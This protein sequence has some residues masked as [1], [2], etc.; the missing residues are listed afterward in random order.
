MRKIIIVDADLEGGQSFGYYCETI[1]EQISRELGALTGRE[2]VE[3]AVAKEYDVEKLGEGDVLV[4][5]TYQKLPEGYEQ[6]RKNP[7]LKVVVLTA[8]PQVVVAQKEWMN[9]PG[10]IP[11]TFG[12]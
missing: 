1:C 6:A 11:S 10:F 3:V 5:V 12:G 4:F 8:L 7:L 9:L 2:P